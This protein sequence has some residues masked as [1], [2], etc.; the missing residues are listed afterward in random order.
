LNNMLAWFARNGVASNLL[1]MTIVV[2]GVLTISSIKMEIF[3]EFEADLI[4]VSV[5]Y[6]GAAPAEVEEG[7]CVRIEE[8]IQDLEGIKKLSSTA[9]EG[10]GT[11]SIEVDTGVDSRK[12][13]DEVKSRVDAISTFPEETE[14]PIV[15]EIVLRRQVINVAVAGNTDET[16]LKVLA[17]QIR[18][19][20]LA[21]PGISQVQLSSVRPYEIS[22]E[23][24]EAALR[25]YGLT[26]TEVV[27]AVRNSSLDLPGGS[28]KT[29][30]GEIL[31]RSK[32][33][34]YLG[35]EYDKI[36]LRSRSDGTRLML[37]D[38]A[39]VV[40]GFAETDLSSRFDGKP[41]ALLQVYRVG[42]ENILGIAGAVHD[43]VAKRQASLPAGIQ[44]T[45]WQD[46][47]RIFQGRL[48]LMV[49]NGQLGFLLVFICLAL[50]LRIRLA[51]WVA[52]G[53]VISFLGTFW[54]MPSVGTSVNMLSLFA[55]IVVLGIV[56]DDAIV[57]GENIYV[58]QL[59]TKDS[60]AASTAGVQEVATP[61]FFAILTSIAAFSPLLFVDGIMGKFFKVIPTVVILMLLFSLVESLLILPAHLRHGEPEHRDKPRSN[62]FWL[63]HPFYLALFYG[64]RWLR[65]LQDFVT[66]Q[67]KRF[68]NTVYAPLL[69]KA[70]EW[71]YASVAI[72]VGLMVITAGIV[73]AG[74]IKFEFFPSVESEYVAAGLTMPQGTPVEVTDR[75]IARIEES[76]LQ[77]QKE[78]RENAIKLYPEDDPDVISHIMASIGEQPYA[79]QQQQ[80][81]GGVGGG[82]SA[83]HIGEVTLALARSEERSIGS[84]EIANRWRELVGSIPD[85]VQ[86]NYASS[87]FNSGDPINIELSST[88]YDQL[89]QASVELKQK[90]ADY[91]GVFDISD[92]FRAGKQEVK[93]N[94]KPEGEALGV[95]LAN[96][97]R[98]VRQ[99]FFGEEAQR[100]QRGRDDIRV[101]VRYP[102]ADRRSL[103]D[104]ENMRVRTATGAEVPFSLA[105]EAELGRGYSSI[106]RV[107][108]RRVIAVT[109]DVDDT[110][111]NA[112]EI[113]GDVAASY[114]PNLLA[115][116]PGLTYSL[117]GEQRNQAESIASLGTGF[118]VAMMAIYVL[119]AIPFKS[120]VQPLIVMSAIPFGVVGAVWGHLL[121]GINLSL[122]SMF[123]IVA[124][125]G[126]VVND[127]LVLVDFINRGRD[128]G[129]RLHDVIRNAG[130]ARFRPVLLT[131]LTTFA[132]LS[133]MLM[134]KSLQAQFLIPMAVSLAFGVIF[135]TSITLML[136]PIG[137]LII[138]DFTAL[139]A[140]IFG[141]REEPVIE[142]AESPAG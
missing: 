92:S 109:A 48:D 24:S 34:A 120:Y 83:A 108:R 16:T 10:V 97:A 51:F 140:R 50:F 37:S 47:S 75:I 76:A 5:P 63:F 132:G 40:D 107:D 60:L 124:L 131:S 102:E 72:G 21:Q 1:M 93:L 117:E 82:S 98:Q 90:L 22:V 70:L 61:V 103:G 84:L 66:Y 110:K 91:P 39:R 3:P 133:P 141:R 126:V 115:K 14:K 41:T 80:N 20:L 8:A 138:E 99:A 65:G 68:I 73:G 122:L 135:A 53:I 25:R 112:N 56:V 114:L 11:I 127:S 119:L 57:A 59:R 54:L 87:L 125:A 94:V 58:H 18:E 86:L 19:D 100:I 9:S 111:A 123:G 96:L 79:A 128:S 121:M 2:G 55:F 95:T 42:D 31:L 38:V 64:E 105:A 27:Q 49:N 130:M 106:R 134:E 74:W 88:N 116:Y 23:V 17:E 101:M 69:E 78:L 4:I 77:L 67:L 89:Q 32:G 81:G 36:A 46:Q 28:V 142:P 44:L 45:T 137:Y 62:V 85:A 43:Y 15:R 52:L 29:A 113:L 30:G 26:F 104:L 6:L 129:M 118:L 139:F 136:V 71:R 33:Q 35:S 12:L 13:L 7:V